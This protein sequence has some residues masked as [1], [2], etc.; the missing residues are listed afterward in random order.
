MILFVEMQ[1]YSWLCDVGYGLFGPLQPILIE[2]GV[3]QQQGAHQFKIIPAGGELLSLAR[4]S[5]NLWKPIYHFDRRTYDL[6]DFEPANF[7]NSLSPRS[8]FTKNLIVARPSLT[9][10]TMIR[11][12]IFAT[13]ERETQTRQRIE[14]SEHLVDMLDRHFSISLRQADFVHLPSGLTPIRMVV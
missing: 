4:L 3:V 12:N 5:Q 7:Y 11:N 6:P 14:S 10:G 8:I 2:P 1:S 13:V 9:G